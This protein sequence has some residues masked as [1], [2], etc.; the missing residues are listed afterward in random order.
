MK[1]IVMWL[2]GAAVIALWWVSIITASPLVILAVVA[3]LVTCI[4]FGIYIYN[5][6][7]KEQ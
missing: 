7:D 3:S 4:V 6:W 2:W 5:N 1:L